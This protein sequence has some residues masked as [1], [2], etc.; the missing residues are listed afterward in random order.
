MVGCKP[1][2]NDRGL[3]ITGLRITLVAGFPI[4]LNT[5][6][7]FRRTPPDYQ[8]KPV[9]HSIIS[10]HIHSWLATPAPLRG[11]DAIVRVSMPSIV[12]RPDPFC[13]SNCGGMCDCD[14]DCG[15]VQLQSDPR[16]VHLR[17]WLAFW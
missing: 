3:R 8:M 17:V 11:V 14:P 1:I 7:F 2:S 4:H 10:I 6:H 5:D 9:L 13:D 12:L 16:C 15:P